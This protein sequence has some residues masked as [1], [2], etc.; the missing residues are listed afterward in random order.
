MPADK[1]NHLVGATTRYIAG[2]N[3]MQTSYWRTGPDGRLIKYSK[4]TEFGKAQ[5]MPAS[6]R[7][8]YANRNYL[9]TK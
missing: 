3:A 7:L 8:A 1:L 2:R 4:V 5:K 9:S 6:I